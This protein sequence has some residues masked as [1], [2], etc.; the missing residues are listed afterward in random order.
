LAEGDDP[1]VIGDGRGH[2]LDDLMRA[3][4][5]FLRFLA[6]DM[7]ALIPRKPGGKCRSLATPERD[8]RAL[9]AAVRRITQNGRN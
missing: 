1:T 9:T 2:R 4:L 8:H 7:A 3:A 5:E 6:V